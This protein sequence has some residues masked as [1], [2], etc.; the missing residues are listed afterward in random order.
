MQ[1]EHT[2]LDDT[3]CVEKYKELITELKDSF[4]ERD[5]EIDILATSLIS[6]Q[7]AVLVGPP[8]TGKSLLVRAFAKALETSYFDYLITPYTTPDEIIGPISLKNLKEKDTIV[9]NLKGKIADSKV[10]F[11]DEVFKGNSGTSNAMLSVINEK[12]VDAGNGQKVKVPL[13][14]LIGASNEYPTGS[15]LSAFW[16]RWVFRREVSDIKSDFS[17]ERMWLRPKT[18][19]NIQSKISMDDIKAIRKIAET[20]DTK[21]IFKYILELRNFAKEKQIQITL[22]RWNHARKALQARAAIDGRSECN[23]SDIAILQDV[24]WNK[25][26]QRKDICQKITELCYSYLSEAN[27]I[28]DA[29]EQ[30]YNIADTGRCDDGTPATFDQ[31]SA[32]NARLKEAISELEKIQEKHGSGKIEPMINKVIKMQKRIARKIAQSV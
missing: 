18:I 15:S 31:V 27:E 28:V 23:E 14:L 25:P 19:G 1:N 30:Q 10:V 11:L 22:R 4:L 9:R 17:F 12:V 21:P 2:K 16:D 20:V 3:I 5:Q 8:G 13:E 32:S 6:E 29:A 26:S 7:S 24:L